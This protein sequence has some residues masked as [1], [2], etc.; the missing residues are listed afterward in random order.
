VD[1]VDWSIDRDDG[2]ETNFMYAHAVYLHYLQQAWF[3]DDI[4]FFVDM[5]HDMGGAPTYQDAL[6]GLLAEHGADFV[7]TVAP[8]ARWLAYI[9]ETHDDGAHFARGALW[10]EIVRQPVLG[11]TV[12]VSPMVLGSAYLDV[13]ASYTVSLSSPLPDDATVVVQQV[14]GNDANSDGD[15]LTLPATV[16]A[17]VT[18]IVTV[19]PAGDYDVLERTDAT[20]DVALQFE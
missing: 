8:Y 5:W 15:V 4:G 16:P 18:L 7:A 3:D 2:Y 20:V 19:L 1:H 12:T 6:D 10:P 11:G 13:D 9:G 17:G 14:P